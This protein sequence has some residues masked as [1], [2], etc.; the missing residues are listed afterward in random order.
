VIRLFA[1]LLLC[2]AA[3][4]QDSSGVPADIQAT[5][6]RIRSEMRLPDATPAPAAAEPPRQAAPPIA[7][8]ELEADSEDSAILLRTMRTITVD[9]LLTSAALRDAAEQDARD[10]LDAAQR[11]AER[12][13]RRAERMDDL[14]AQGAVPA[15]AAASAREEAARRHNTLDLATDRA[16]MLSELIEMARADDS[17]PGGARRTSYGT[18]RY[19]G[20]G[21]L[22]RPAE[23]A[24]LSASFQ[25]RFSKPLPISAWGETAMHAMLGFDHHGRV[26]VAVGPDSPEGLWIRAWLERA[27]IPYYGFRTA[28]LGRSTGPHIHI[29]PGSL[30]VR[31]FSRST[32]RRPAAD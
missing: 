31:A 32:V 19:D 21:R 15:D 24:T 8:E 12:A 22:I 9:D 25:K 7:P 10:M 13:D 28:L 4:A 23:V 20:S 27:H 5:V 11:M 29:G 17:A 1:G 18:L 26:D 30:R 3:A 2:A 16:A 14:A 6:D